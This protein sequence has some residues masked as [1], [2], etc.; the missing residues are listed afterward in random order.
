MGEIYQ[1]NDPLNFNELK[2]GVPKAVQGGGYYS[3]IKLSDEPLYIQ[4]PKIYTKNGI[5]VTGKRIYTDLLFDR[6]DLDFISFINNIEDCVKKL[7]YEKRSIWFTEEPSIEDIE[8]NWVTSIKTY[9]NHK[10]LLRTNIEK[11]SK[12]ISLQIWNQKEEEINIT[13]IEKDSNI[14][15]IFEIS[16]LKFSST[17]FHL[18]IVLKQIMKFEKVELFSKC[19]IKQRKPT[20]IEKIKSNSDSENDDNELDYQN[21]SED[22]S[23]DSESDYNSDNSLDDNSELANETNND[24][25]ADDNINPNNTN[26]DVK[27]DANG[28]ENE[29]SN[30]TN[31]DNSNETNDDN[32]NETNDDNTVEIDTNVEL[33]NSKNIVN[34]LEITTYNGNLENINNSKS[35]ED[36]PEDNKKDA[37]T[38]IEEVKEK[39]TNNLENI[40]KEISD[41]IEKQKNDSSLEK[42]QDDFELS[43][44]TLDILNNNSEILELRK[45]DD[46]YLEI[47]KKTLE[48]AREAKN[49]AIKAYLEAKK[50][51]NEYV[52]DE[53]DSSD[54]ED[55]E[56][57]SE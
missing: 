40:N 21:N 34:N 2:L 56:D 50:I 14:I 19:L 54:G 46:V 15:S 16:G 35:L 26:D 23:D 53:M 51:K 45:P 57:L 29:T 8:D 13:D 12:N 1:Y 42:S 33:D 24:V 49:Q 6:D 25:E 27:I 10:F 55:L 43:E 17:S 28:V 48:K 31:D 47:Y 32:S 11:N 37:N 30:E 9:K 4:T 38:E 41:E 36:A 7:I 39:K 44:V 52:L 18:D 5:T 3:N 20:Y 22:N